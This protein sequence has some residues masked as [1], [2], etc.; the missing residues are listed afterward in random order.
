[1]R[2][3]IDIQGAQTGSRHRGIG[4]YALALATA[5]A[6]TPRHHEISILLNGVFEEALADLVD[7]F[8]AMMPRE[9]IYTFHISG[10]V[11][12]LVPANAWRKAAAEAERQWLID[13][14]DP[15]V[16]LVTSLFEG[17]IDG[18]VTAIPRRRSRTQV[19]C[20]L[21]DLIPFSDPAKYLP[22]KVSSDWYYSKVESLKNADMLL[23][24]S[25]SARREACDFVGYDPARART[26]M[27]AASSLFTSRAGQDGNADML[28]RLN[29]TRRFIMHTSAFEPRK[30]FEGLVRA[31]G[32]IPPEVRAPYQLVFVSAI[33][34]EDQIRVRGIA[35]DYG[36]GPDELVYAG[37]VN[38]D[39][40]IA[41]YSECDLFAFPPFHEGFGLPALEA[42][43]CG[44]PVIGSNATS[45]PE[46]IGREDAL[47]DP[48]DDQSIAA[49]LRRVME[50]PDFQQSL[51]EHSAE[52]AKRFSWE[53]TAALALDAIETLPVLD[54]PAMPAGLGDL[55][56]AIAT[57]PGYPVAEDLVSLSNAISKTFDGLGIE[58]EGVEKSAA[59]TADTSLPESPA[60]ANE[61]DLLPSPPLP[62]TIPAVLPIGVPIK[63]YS[64]HVE[65]SG[66]LN[67]LLL[68][69]DHIGDFLISLEAFRHVRTTWPE[70]RITLVCGPWNKDLAQSCGL[71]DEIVPCDFLPEAGAD[72]DKDALHKEGLAKF[73]ACPLGSYDIA[74]D[75]RY[76]EDTRFLLNYVDANRRVGY[77]GG[78]VDLDLSLPEV[79]ET[80]M[81]AQVGARVMA[82]ASAMAWTYAPPEGGARAML[83]GQRPA[84]RL[85]DGRPT[86]GLAPGAGNPIKAWGA[87]RFAALA[88]R[89]VENLDCRIVIVGGKR[90]VEDAATIAAPL[91]ADKVRNFAGN[92]PLTDLAPVLA[93]L[94][95]YIGNDTGTTHLAAAL[96]ISTLCLFS[97]QSHVESWRPN[98]RHVV[99]LKGSV[100]C[101]PCYLTKL[102]ACP[103]DHWCME[104]SP[105]RVFEE[106]R[107]L[108]QMDRYLL[109][110]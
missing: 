56:T 21:Y 10:N 88:Q 59:A 73:R 94:D 77:T 79:P 89:F 30:N 93:G 87:E 104:I 17:A 14:I 58:L 46:V 63:R 48:Y 82:L 29:I 67:I 54:E 11:E 74:A 64:A 68:K 61:D 49:L 5:I 110:A 40:L 27:S 19:A 109:S 51:R 71:F 43:C 50:E 102:S 33:S 72:Y 65:T 62:W 78:G 76:Y 25:D 22:N 13:R 57:L 53:A 95:L 32:Q 91:A 45:I 69:L 12:G 52:Q 85:F 83:L 100:G 3:L 66:Q 1:M 86:I 15:D 106:A 42:M 96:G 55:Y 99:T 24:I 92:L 6:R 36:L 81:R 2:I 44:A 26:I 47:F 18:G 39:E 9:R 97:G 34:L 7:T 37:R 101:S 35:D 105:A 90:D 103:R 60:A 16:V 75:F 108:I 80:S 70:A 31:F 107:Q 20:V 41:L 38:D 28:R 84:R 4:R 23:A 8:S 98:G